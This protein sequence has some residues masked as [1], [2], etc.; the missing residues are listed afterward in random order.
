MQV[1]I[2]L[3]L[4]NKLIE[5]E[6]PSIETIFMGIDNDGPRGPKDEGLFYPQLYST[7]Y[8][9]SSCL[10]TI[11]FAAIGIG[12]S[13][14]E[15]QFMFSGHWPNKPLHET[16]SLAYAAKK[17]AEAAPG[18]GKETDII[19]VAMTPSMGVQQ[20]QEK[21]I[22]ELERIYQKSR[23]ATL[24]G[25]QRAQDETKQLI[26]QIKKEQEKA[27]SKPSDSQK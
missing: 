2:V 14:A 9:K 8:D 27:Q 5:Y 23:R 6:L 20:A 3:E 21:Y 26:E 13:H 24:R 11:G 1:D 17:R 16:V 25:I 18:V 19:I 7:W 4:K 15:S 22:K 10:T 12:K